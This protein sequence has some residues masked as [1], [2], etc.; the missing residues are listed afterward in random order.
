MRP[1]ANQV[2]DLMSEINQR[3]EK[4]KGFGD[5]LTK[6]LAEQL[7]DYFSEL[8]YQSVLPTF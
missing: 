5:N 4:N 8:S 3:I 2:D 7:T 6:R 1:V